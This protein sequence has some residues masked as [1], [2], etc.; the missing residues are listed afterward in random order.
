[1]VGT[2]AIGESDITLDKPVTSLLT[3]I[4][5]L[6]DGNTRCLIDAAASGKPKCDI[7]YLVL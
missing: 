2:T 4:M 1:M 5:L 6:M 7:F 3:F